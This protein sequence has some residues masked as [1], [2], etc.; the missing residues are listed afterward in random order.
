[1]VSVTD[2][3]VGQLKT[4]LEQKGRPNASLRV[5]VAPGGCS[6]FQYGMTLEDDVEEGDHVIERDGIKLVV[7]PFSAL[8]LE[9]AEVDYSENLMGGGFTIYNPSA[10]SSCACGQSFN[11]AQGGG[12]AQPCN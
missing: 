12:H 2:Q 7:D 9:G 8:Y 1:M 3:A 6:G 11:T 10:V 5:Y 4:I